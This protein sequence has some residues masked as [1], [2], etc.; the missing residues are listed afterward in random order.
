MVIRTLLLLTAGCAYHGPIHEQRQPA[1][2]V[3]MPDE[4]YNFRWPLTHIA[5]TS[6]YGKRGRKFHEGLDLRA[7]PG[8]PVHA[9]AA[10]KVIYSGSRIRGYGRVIVIRHDNGMT[11]VYAHNSRLI[12]KPNKHVEQGQVIALSGSSGRCR[13]PHVHFEMRRGV[14]TINPLHLLPLASKPM[15]EYASSLV[16]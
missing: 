1:E 11:T 3:S 8:T 5:V 6:P 16:P 7:R 10:G 2:L 14:A 9:A 12:V 15:L 13:G 4:N